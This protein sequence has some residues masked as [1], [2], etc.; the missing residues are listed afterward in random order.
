M[1][2][3]LFALSLVE[4]VRGVYTNKQVSYK[5]LD[6]MPAF[7]GKAILAGVPEVWYS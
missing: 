4:E 7:L 2:S 3:K 6:D 1:I 5:Q